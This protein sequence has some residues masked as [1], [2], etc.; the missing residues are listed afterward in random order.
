VILLKVN[1][2]APIY[3]KIICTLPLG[4]FS[5]STYW[6]VHDWRCQHSDGL[7]RALFS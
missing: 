6:D 2:V 5:I 3:I 7:C 4:R 1:T